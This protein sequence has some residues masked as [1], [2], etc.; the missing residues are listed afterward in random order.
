[1]FPRVP[2]SARAARRPLGRAAAFATD[3]HARTHARTNTGY[4]RKRGK[5]PRRTNV[6]PPLFFRRITRTVQKRS[7]TE[8]RTVRP[9]FQREI[10]RERDYSDYRQWRASGVCVCAYLPRG[11]RT[12]FPP[13]PLQPPV[14]P[15][16]SRLRTSHGVKRRVFSLVLDDHGNKDVIRQGLFC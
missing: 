9:R 14:V 6:S 12:S 15:V 4:R 11:T 5:H 13:L 2:T 16:H 8:W 10:V 7:R 3:S 1:L